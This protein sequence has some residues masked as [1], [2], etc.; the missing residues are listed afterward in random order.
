MNTPTEVVAR[1]LEFVHQQD[2]DREIELFAS[3]AVVEFPFAPQGVPGRFVGRTEILRMQKALDAGR[4]PAIDVDGDD[5]SW[6]IRQTGDPEV[7]VL[8][9]DVPVTDPNTGNAHRLRQIHVYRIVDGLIH[10]VRDYFGPDT[11]AFVRA[12]LADW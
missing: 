9:L 5:V 7:A 4:G 10:S 2:R 11:A 6:T 8:E 3:D 1:R 12:S